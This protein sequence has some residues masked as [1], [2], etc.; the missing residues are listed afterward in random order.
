[1]AASNRSKTK[2]KPLLCE[3]C[4]KEWTKK[5]GYYKDG[6][7]RYNNICDSCRWK[8]AKGELKIKPRIKTYKPYKYMVK[9]DKCWNC[10]FIPLHSIQLEIDHIDGNNKNND[11]INLQ[12]LCCNCHRLKTLLNREFLVKD[13]R[14][15]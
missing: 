14:N 3:E 5:V 15:K 9:K 1:M 7:P 6:T 11:I 13:K 8:R 4:K 12:V 2:D 10:G